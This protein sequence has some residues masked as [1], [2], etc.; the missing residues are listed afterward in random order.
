[1]AWHPNNPSLFASCNNDGY[2]DIFDLTRDMELPIAHKKVNDYAQ[3][4]CQWNNEG[5][6]IAT[7]DS[8]GS[9]NLFILAE[10]YRKMDNSKYEDLARYLSQRQESD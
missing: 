8:Y 3:N 10:K 6:A 1:V 9:I 4:K 5:S 7:G 2:I